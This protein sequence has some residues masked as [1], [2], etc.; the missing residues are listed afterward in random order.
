LLFVVTFIV[1]AFAQFL[2]WQVAK[3]AGM[4]KNA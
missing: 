3:R 2:I 1:R 4:S